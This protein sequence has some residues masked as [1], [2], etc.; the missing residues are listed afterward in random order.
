MSRV[1]V[2]GSPD[3]IEEFKKWEFENVVVQYYFEGNLDPDT[4]LTSFGVVFDL[5]LDEN[6]HNLLMYEQYPNLTVVGCAVKQSLL[7]MT[8]GIME[9]IPFRLVGMNAVPSF[10]NRDSLEV[11]LLN[12]EDADEIRRI[13][14]MFGKKVEIVDDRVGM[15]TPRIVCMIINEACFVLGEGTADIAGVDRAM[16][17]GTAYPM[18]PFQWADAIGVQ[19]VYEILEAIRD[20]SGDDKY[21]IAP[22]LKKAYLKNER[23]YQVE[24]KGPV[25]V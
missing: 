5:N 8:H 2:V 16:Q 23:F 25:A 18:G 13:G 3:R 6:S 20:D 12:E 7:E 11:S 1:L 14:E 10:I 21:K 4:D 19:N 17:L 15:V 9:S 22:R 24:K